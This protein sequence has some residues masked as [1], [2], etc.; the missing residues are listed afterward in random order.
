MAKVMAQD[1]HFTAEEMVKINKAIAFNSSGNVVEDNFRSLEDAVDYAM[2]NPKVVS[3]REGNIGR[4]G[5]EVWR[6]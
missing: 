5:K 4:Q 1:K 2:D 3:I 6:K